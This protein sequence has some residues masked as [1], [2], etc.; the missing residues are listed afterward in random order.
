M[1]TGTLQKNRTTRLASYLPAYTALWFFCVLIIC[2]EFRVN[3][4]TFIWETD[5][6]PQHF[7]SFNYLCDYLR[8]RGWTF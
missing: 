1:E 3:G 8:A 7:L 4:K 5:G 2:L 6:V